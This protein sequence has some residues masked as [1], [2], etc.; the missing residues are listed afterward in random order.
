MNHRGWVAHR[1]Q[2]PVGWASTR[3]FSDGRG[4]I[5]QLAVARP[6]RGLGLGR[7]L[8]LHALAD[9]RAQGATSFGLGVQGANASAIRLYRNVGFEVEREW[10]VYAR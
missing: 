6:E 5:E 9:L 4:W 8:L 10:R 7:A 3:R 1:E 2:Q